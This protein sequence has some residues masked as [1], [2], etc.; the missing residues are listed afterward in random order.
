[1][2]K[3]HFLINLGFMCR[4][5][6]IFEL[7]F[8][9]IVPNLAFANLDYF[10]CGPDEDGCYPEIY[11]HCLCI[12]SHPQNANKPYCL[13]FSSLICTPLAETKDCDEDLI[14]T[15]QAS[16]LAVIFHSTEHPPCMRQSKQFCKEHH[17]YFCN[18]GGNP[19]SCKKEEA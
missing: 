15:N 6:K 19:E 9:T 16:C 10:L 4:F 18:E 11:E 13:D 17:S 1:M 14:Y 5:L 8:L 2:I 12:P 7:I 3:D